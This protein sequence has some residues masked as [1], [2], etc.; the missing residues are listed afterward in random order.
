MIIRNYHDAEAKLEPSHGG[1]GLIKN[2]RLFDAGD[3][4]TNLRF[5]IYS[6]LKPGTS[7]GEHMHGKDEEVYV[8]LEGRGRVIVNGQSREVR[9][10][11]SS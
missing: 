9:L 7:I 2:V 5:I 6:E 1:G 11:T 10:A 3:F 4:N 8:I